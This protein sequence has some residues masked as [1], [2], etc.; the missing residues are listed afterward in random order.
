MIESKTITYPEF[1]EEPKRQYTLAF[2]RGSDVI[3]RYREDGKK[4]GIT[5]EE[6]PWYFCIE[7]AEAKKHSHEISQLIKRKLIYHHARE[8]KFIRLYCRN[9]NKRNVMDPKNQVLKRFQ[10]LGIKTYEADLN[11]Y[12]R[13]LVDDDLEIA[14]DYE[15]LYFDIETD[16]RGKGIVIG[17][18]QILS[19]AAM[20]KNGKT[21]YYTGDEKKLLQK[22]AKRMMEYDV[23]SGWNSEKFDIPYIKERM[24]VHHIKF[25]W[26]EILQLDLMQKVM[27][28]NKRNVSLIKEVRSF[29]LNA[30][31]KHFLGESKVDHKES[32]WE[33]YTQMPEKLKEYNI[34]DVALLLKLDKKLSLVKQKVI[35]MRIAGC[36]LNEFAVSRILDIYI[37]RNANG[38]R[39]PSKPNRD[40]YNFNDKESSYVGGYVF[41]PIQGV[42]QNVYHFD[43]TSLYPSIIQTFNIS[44]ETWLGEDDG[45]HAKCI[46]SPNGQK[47]SR[48]IGIIPKIITDLLTARNNIRHNDMKKY[49]EGSIEYENLYYQQYAFKTFANSFYGILGAGFTRYYKIQNAEAITLSGHYL[50]KLAEKWFRANGFKVIYGDTDSVFVTGPTKIDPDRTHKEINSFIAYHLFKHFKITDSQIDLKVEDTYKSMLLVS[51]KKYVK[52]LGDKLD[53]KG[54]EAK[55]RETWEFA[56]KNQTLLFEKLLFD[57]AS[58]DDIRSWILEL[59]K[60]VTSGK[61]KTDEV[62]LQTRLSKD[63]EDY[64][65]KKKDEFGNV[66]ELLPSKLPHVKV[67]TWL[68]ENKIQ[69][70]DRNSWEKGAYIKFI[71]TSTEGGIQAT[72]PLNYDNDYDSIYYWNVRLYAVLQRVLEAAFPEDDWEQYLIETKKKRKK[73][74]KNQ[75]TLL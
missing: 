54:L 51:K 18:D 6:Y 3:L 1:L 20:N 19:I 32:I 26:R 66:I 56:A 71:V 8:D 75:L 58:K 14:E 30:V 35:E 44:P 16:D 7:Y 33:M 74:N 23:I 68:R 40:E 55:R 60:Y 65:R 38:T 42:H 62:T 11:S 31:S 28:L 43:F 24:N 59:K 47:F 25:N 57:N 17:R 52:N 36:F 10:E 50:I 39:F 12:Q 61:M 73:K 48:E 27:E 49:E 37:L 29:A 5:I 70:D 4:K 53:I 22:F 69:D 34:Q 67:A 41:D 15:V 64:A 45:N 13:C 21:Y 9:S 2:D 72:S 63:I 46:L